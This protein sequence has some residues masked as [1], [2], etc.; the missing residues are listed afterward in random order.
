MVA[1]LSTQSISIPP[2]FAVVGTAFRMSCRLI[3]RGGQK[4]SK[5]FLRVVNKLPPF[6][7]GYEAIAQAI[8]QVD[9]DHAWHLCRNMS[10]S[11][12]ALKP[13]LVNLCADYDESRREVD[14]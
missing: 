10:R 9:I 13:E 4:M 8:A 12:K 5:P 6:I 1:T 3:F 2:L 14:G 7:D 11:A